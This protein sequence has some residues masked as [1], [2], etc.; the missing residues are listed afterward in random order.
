MRQLTDI[1]KYNLFESFMRNIDEEIINESLQS[2]ILQQ[3]AKQLKPFG[4]KN[5]NNY[6]NNKSFSGIFGSLNV[7]WDKITDNDFEKYEAG[8][9]AGIKKARAVLASGDKWI[10]AVILFPNADGKTFDSMICY[11]GYVNFKEH[12][13][14][15][16]INSYKEQPSRDF[17]TYKQ[18]WI[19]EDC[20]QK[21][22]YILEIKDFEVYDI[23]GQRNSAKLGSFIPGD[24]YY[25]KKVA[26]ENVERYKKIIA[27]RK[28]ERAAKEDN[29]AQQVQ[30]IVNKVLELSAKAATNP[31]K[32]VDIQYRIAYLL[33]NIYSTSRWDSKRGQTG[34][35]GLLY[36]FKNYLSNHLSMAKDGG[37]GFER[38]AQDKTKTQIEKCIENINKRIEEIEEIIAK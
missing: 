16:E 9:K 24:A 18:K 31:D 4:S 25:Y 30:E 29:I 35:D 26:E 33:E 21:D 7:A 27:K 22:F 10:N 32:F 20:E 11:R 13:W 1:I 2:S 12:K 38:S 5:N 17:E 28:A 15:Y 6:W 36:L 14:D 3:L 23:R 37:Y 19:K 8:D 34:T